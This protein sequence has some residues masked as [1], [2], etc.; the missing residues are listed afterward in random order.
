M[1]LPFRHNL[2]LHH[3][4]GAEVLIESTGGISLFYLQNRSQLYGNYTS[5]MIKIRGK[6]YCRH[7][8]VAP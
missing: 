3:R 8:L 4:R 6:S 5:S 2:V 1:T 7:R